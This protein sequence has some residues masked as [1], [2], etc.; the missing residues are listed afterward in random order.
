M[1]P[2][3]SSNSLLA[4][5]CRVTITCFWGK[6]GVI[7][8]FCAWVYF[9]SYFLHF[10]ATPERHTHKCKCF[11][12]AGDQIHVMWHVTTSKNRNVPCTKIKTADERLKMCKSVKSETKRVLYKMAILTHFTL[13]YCVCLFQCC[14][15]TLSSCCLPDQYTCPLMGLSLAARQYALFKGQHLNATFHMVLFFCIKSCKNV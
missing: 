13:I 2:L 10:E 14:W 6:T 7:H 4:V 9:L 11:K 12:N 1:L 3:K 15:V 5:L 8:S